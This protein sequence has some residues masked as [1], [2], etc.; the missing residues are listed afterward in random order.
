MS[1]I[2]FDRDFS[3]LSSEDFVH[4][5]IWKS[6][7]VSRFVMG[8]DHQFGRNRAGT[9]E[10]VRRLGSELGVSVD[11]VSRQEVEETT[12]RS[13][14]IRNAIQV[15]GDLQLASSFLEGYHRL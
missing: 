5:I 15:G 6:I 12:A 2:R 1:V 11:V 13:T 3:L 7:G 10:T 9:I 14:A 4:E 8:Y